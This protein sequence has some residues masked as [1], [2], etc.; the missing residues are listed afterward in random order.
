MSLIR[1]VT[2]YCSSSPAISQVYF[3]AAR[4]LG[5]AIARQ[6]W[7][8]IYGG[9]FLGLMAAVAQAAR[10][11][12]GK[13]IGITPQLLVDKGYGDP[14]CDELIVTP[15][16]RERKAIMEQRGDAFIALPGG[17]GTFEEI[18]EIIAA[19]SLRYHDKP[20]VLLNIENYY[21]PLLAMIEQGVEQQFIKPKARDLYHV[22]ASVT[23]MMT[24]LLAYVPPVPHPTRSDPIPPSAAE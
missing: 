1:C 9:N 24:Y 13:V 18:F 7:S 20:I 22:A 5:C 2:V 10:N 15:G 3:D 4:E 17:L 16:M 6:Q 19:K 14:H 23:D 8:L 11:A 12:G 21:R